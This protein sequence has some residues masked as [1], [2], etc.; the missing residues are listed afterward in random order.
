MQV[1]IYRQ[2][3]VIDNK[4]YSRKADRKKQSV[5]LL[6]NLTIDFHIE[7]TF[8]NML[9]VICPQGYEIFFQHV[10]DTFNCQ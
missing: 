7:G 3:V 5:L 2:Q 6:A 10:E 8:Y 4:G 9:S 1:Q